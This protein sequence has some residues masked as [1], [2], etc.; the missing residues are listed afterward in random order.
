MMAALPKQ[1][2]SAT[3]KMQ[4][5]VTLGLF[6][7]PGHISVILWCHIAR[8]EDPQQEPVATY[9]ALRVLAVITTRTRILANLAIFR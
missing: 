2:P 3:A 9:P 1:T 4:R 8:E 5:R 7:V 6:L